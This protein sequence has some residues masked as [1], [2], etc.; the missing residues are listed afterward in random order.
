MKPLQA[1][2]FDLDGTLVNSLPATFEAFH[3]AIVGHGGPQM[4]NEELMGHFGPGEL[5]IFEKLLG[6]KKAASAWENYRD[7]L[8]H[9]IHAI[10]LFHGISELLGDLK[11]QSIRTGVITGRGRKTTDLLLAH[12]GLIDHFPIVIT[13]DEVSHSKPSPEGIQKVCQFL[14]IDPSA[15][16]Y[17]GDSTVD[18]IAA[19]RAGATSIAALWDSCA[20]RENLVLH[21]PH[22]LV[23]V[24]AEILAIA[25]RRSY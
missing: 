24:P 3:E 9:K 6:P 17:V 20:D 15:T 11:K 7:R 18:V 25:L 23:E 8:G 2:L 22:H 19:Q 13:H 4:T 10:E 14:A 1:V 16:A 5:Q 12:L 21:S